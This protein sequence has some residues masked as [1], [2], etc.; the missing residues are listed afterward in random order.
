MVN[1]F[2]D[3][4]GEEGLGNLQV[5][6]KV[7]AVSGRYVDYINEIQT[8]HK[9]GYPAYR[10]ASEGSPTL[11]FTYENRV[12]G[13]GT[14]DQHPDGLSKV[15]VTK[16]A[17]IKGDRGIRGKRGAT[18]EAS[19]ISPHGPKGVTGDIGPSGGAGVKGDRGD[20]GPPGP[21]GERGVAGVQGKK[22]NAGWRGPKG[23]QGVREPVIGVY[24]SSRMKRQ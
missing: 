15:T 20:A 5:L 4:I 9:L 12:F 22:V 23:E 8:S 6:R 10:I 24:A 13:L 19:P 1:V 14:H 2:G 11:V 17:S 18:S 3:S 7:I 21:K 16:D